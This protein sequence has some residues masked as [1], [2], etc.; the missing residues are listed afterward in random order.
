MP[1]ML[2]S[3]KSPGFGRQHNSYLVFEEVVNISICF[4]ISKVV[5]K[6]ALKQVMLKQYRDY[7]FFFRA[8]NH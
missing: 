1:L 7:I 5:L 3:I 2:L 4:A 8:R 6:L